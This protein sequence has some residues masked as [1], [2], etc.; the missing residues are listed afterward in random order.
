[1]SN[2][3]IQCSFK[4]CSHHWKIHKMWQVCPKYVLPSFNFKTFQWTSWTLSHFSHCLHIIPL[5]LVAYPFL[6]MHLVWQYF[7]PTSS[8]TWTETWF[9]AHMEKLVLLSHKIIFTCTN[10]NTSWNL[11]NLSALLWLTN[12]SIFPHTS[13]TDYFLKVNRL[14]YF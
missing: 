7:F 13:D 5:S 8:I 11:L 4:G 10:G 9:C 2:Q 12:T 3:G 14:S 1:M 6:W